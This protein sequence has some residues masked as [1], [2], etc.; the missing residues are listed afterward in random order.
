MERKK[1]FAII[2]SDITLI[3]NSNNIKINVNF[4][5]SQYYLKLQYTLKINF[6]HTYESILFHMDLIF[7]P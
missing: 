6:R 1:I 5:F 7:F 4:I 2:Y 3:F